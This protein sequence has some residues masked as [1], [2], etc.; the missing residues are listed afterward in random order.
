MVSVVNTAKEAPQIEDTDVMHKFPDVFPRGLPGLPLDHATEFVIDLLPGMAPVSNAPYRVTPMELKELRLNYG[1]IRQSYKEQRY[2]LR[3]TLDGVSSNEEFGQRYFEDCFQDEDR[4]AHATHLRAALQ[5][6]KREKL[7]AKFKKCE[8]WL[9]EV[10]FLGH[11]VSADALKITSDLIDEVKVAILQDPHLK[12]VQEDLEK[13]KS[14]PEFT[15]DSDK[16]LKY[17]R[18]L[19]IPES[20]NSNI[21]NRIMTEA[22]YTPYSVH[23]GSTKMYHDLRRLYWWRGMKVDVARFVFQC[24]N[25]Q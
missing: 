22:H 16:V 24:L 1:V 14:N 4:E 19:C 17:H 9:K 15:L 5:R 11:I 23:P 21:R 2:S 20:K 7:Y 3:L 10:A 18:R 25:Y 8:F 13:G 6:L 12:T